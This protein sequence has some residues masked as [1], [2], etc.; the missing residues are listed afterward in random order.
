MNNKDDIIFVVEDDEMYSM[1]LEYK[2]KKYCDGIIKRFSSGE[3]CINNMYLNPSLIVL[4][5]QL[6]NING[7]ETLKQIKK[8]NPETAVVTLTNNNDINVKKQ[9]LDA[10]IDMHFQKSK[11]TYDEICKTLN[12]LLVVVRSKKDQ[13]EKIHSYV[14]ITTLIA[15]MLILYFSLINK[16]KIIP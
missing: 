13:K 7:L 15:L 10:G 6:P 14:L 9:L 5:Y 16:I 2:L 8:N 1:M 4:D 12:Y 3:D 11:D